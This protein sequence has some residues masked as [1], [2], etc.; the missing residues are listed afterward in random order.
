MTVP[1][2]VLMIRYLN[3]KALWNKPGWKPLYWALGFTC[4]CFMI[5]SVFRTI[6]LSQGYVAL[7]SGWNMV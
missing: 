1:N 6:E 3:D 7:T 4:I 2:S 5:R